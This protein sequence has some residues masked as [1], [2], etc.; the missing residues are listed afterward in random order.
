MK[1][2]SIWS[3]NTPGVSWPRLRGRALPRVLALPDLIRQMSSSLRTLFIFGFDID[4]CLFSNVYQQPIQMH[5]AYLRAQLYRH[6]DE[7]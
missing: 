2:E 7:M 4:A 6:V 1:E 5:N 3:G